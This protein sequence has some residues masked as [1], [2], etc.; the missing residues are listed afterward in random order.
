MEETTP[1]K[2]FGVKRWIVLAL[3]ILGA[4][5][6]FGPLPSIQPNVF[7]PG[8]VLTPLGNLPFTNVPITNTF[9]ATLVADA[10]IL[11][12][13]FYM[14][15]KIKSGNMV[16]SGL[17]NLLESIY[18]FLWDTTESTA[19]RK[20][21][22][23][24]FP[25]IATIFTIVLVS[26]WMELIPGVDSIGVLES[27]HVESIQGYE[28]HELGDTG[29]YWLD[30]ANPYEGADEG[31]EEE[32]AAEEDHGSAE[33]CTTNCTVTP[34]LRAAPT[35]LNFT[36]ALSLIA[37]FM[38]QFFGFAALKFGYMTKFLNFK[39]LVTVP[40]MGAMDFA[41]GFLELISE[42]V[43]VVSFMFRLFGNI[44]AGQLLLFILGSMVSFIIPTALYLFELFVG[45]IQA[46]V[47]YILT[48]IFM[49]Q[50]TVAHGG[51]D[52]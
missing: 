28:A 33:V 26:S 2:R 11:L 8:E 22:K 45:I 51:E 21:G 13:G 20:N 7:L 18:Q 5:L 19:G 16:P 48:L 1:K 43:K 41:V 36:L 15:R 50:A 40:V 44:F 9:L 31:H 39:A 3:I 29:I 14:W 4:Y 25:I 49:S 47:F 35:D 30:G 37:V 38:T 34:Y 24:F 52:H 32:A 17:Y 6:Q 10:I 12:M 23:K 42:F 46:Y 27:P